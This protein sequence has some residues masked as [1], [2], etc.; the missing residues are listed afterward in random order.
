MDTLGIDRNARAEEVSPE[1]YVRLSELLPLRGQ[2]PEDPVA[3][4]PPRRQVP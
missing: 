1:L 4:Q 3:G 2:P